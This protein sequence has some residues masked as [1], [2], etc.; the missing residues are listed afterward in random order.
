[1]IRS[2]YRAVQPNG[3]RSSSRGAFPEELKETE[4]YPESYK[5]AKENATSKMAVSSEMA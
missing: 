4:G 2:A 5:V 1:M 3:F